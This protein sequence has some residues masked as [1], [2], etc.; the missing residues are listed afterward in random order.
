MCDGLLRCAMLLLLIG[1][2]FELLDSWLH[3]LEHLSNLVG[4]EDIWVRHRDERQRVLLSGKKKLG[5]G[6]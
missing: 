1:L 6:T 3:G 2:L 5:N 4:A